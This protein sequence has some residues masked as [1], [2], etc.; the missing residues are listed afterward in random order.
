MKGNIVHPLLG[1]IGILLHRLLGMEGSNLRSN[2][3]LVFKGMNAILIT[4]QSL[5]RCLACAGIF[6]MIRTSFLFQIRDPIH[7]NVGAGMMS[8]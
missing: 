8:N 6:Y 5:L 4:M 3:F 7:M 1:K 2:F